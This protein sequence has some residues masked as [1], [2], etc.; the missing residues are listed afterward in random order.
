MFQTKDVEKIKTHFLYSIFFPENR[1][2][3]EIMRINIIEANRPQMS[4]I[5]CRKPKATNTHS[6]Y[7]THCFSAAKFLHERASLLRYTYL[8][9]LVRPVF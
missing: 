9:C 6:E 1:T 2:V 8:A 4:I 7:V 3:Y 5:T